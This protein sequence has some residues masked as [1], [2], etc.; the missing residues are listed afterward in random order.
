MDP[1][2][3]DALLLSDRTAQPHLDEGDVPADRVERRQQLVTH[4]G[5]K[6]GLGVIRGIGSRAQHLGFAIQPSVVQRER[7]EVRQARCQRNFL[8]RKRW[9]AG[10]GHEGNRADHSV[11]DGERHDH[12]VTEAEGTK[13]RQGFFVGGVASTMS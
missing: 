8:R 2:E 5:E 4:V 11:T 6:D 13:P 1:P 12:Q 3:I 10:A 9:I 7:A